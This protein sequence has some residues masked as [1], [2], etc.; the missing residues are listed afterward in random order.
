MVKIIL[1][2]L[3]Q[4]QGHSDQGQTANIGGNN[5]SQAAFHMG[6]SWAKLGQ[7]GP[8]FGML[9]G[10]DFNFLTSSFSK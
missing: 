5:I 10:L 9:L 3:G 6:P 2:D 7:V 8:K 1:I 4:G